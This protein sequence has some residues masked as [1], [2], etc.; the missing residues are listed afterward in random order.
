MEIIYRNAK[1][2]DIGVLVESRMA[3][4]GMTADDEEYEFIRNNVREYFQQV[5]EGNRCGIILAEHMGV[6]VGTG[7][8]FYYHSVPSKFNP[9]G[10]KAYITSMHAKD[11]YRRQ[12]IATKILNGLLGCAQKRGYHVFLLHESEMGRALYEKCGFIEG[13]AGMIMK[14]LP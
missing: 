13:K 4:I 6:I 11:E 2:N 5:M 8:I 1:E 3:F 14:N 12:G 7:I 10:G 9:W